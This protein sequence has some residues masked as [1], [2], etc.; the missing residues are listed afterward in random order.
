MAPYPFNPIR[1]F[2]T[3]SQKT[4]EDA[5]ADFPV[6]AYDS[7]AEA[8][9]EDEPEPRNSLQQGEYDPFNYKTYYGQQPIILGVSGENTSD[10]ESGNEQTQ[11][12][13][14]AGIDKDGYGHAGYH[15]S[16]ENAESVEF[17]LQ[18]GFRNDDIA[19]DMMAAFVTTGT[20]SSEVGLMHES[21]EPLH[22]LTIDD[23]M[24]YDITQRESQVAA[25]EGT[26]KKQSKCQGTRTGSIDPPSFPQNRT[27]A[28]KKKKKKSKPQ[29]AAGKSRAEQGSKDHLDLYSLQQ[30]EKDS[31]WSK[32]VESSGVNGPG[33]DNLP[34]EEDAMIKKKSLENNGIQ[35]PI[36]EET[37][38]FRA[39]RV[40]E[41]LEP[42]PTTT[43]DSNDTYPLSWEDSDGPY[44]YRIMFQSTEVPADETYLKL[45]NQGTKVYHVAGERKLKVNGDKS[46]KM[47]NQDGWHLKEGFLRKNAI[48]KLIEWRDSMTVAK[49][50]EEVRRRLRERVYI[51]LDMSPPNGPLGDA[52]VF[53]ESLVTLR[54]R[55]RSMP[56]W[57]PKADFFLRLEVP[58]DM[59]VKQPLE[60]SGFL[61]Y[62]DEVRN[63]L[64]E[65][66]TRFK[67]QLADSSITEATLNE[68][69]DESDDAELDRQMNEAIAGIYAPRNVRDWHGEN[70]MQTEGTGKGKTK[71][72]KKTDSTSTPKTIMHVQG[73]DAMLN[74][75]A[76]S[77]RSLKDWITDEMQE[78]LDM[79]RAE[80]KNKG[81]DLSTIRFDDNV[82]NQRLEDRIAEFDLR[83]RN[84][85]IQKCKETTATKESVNTAIELGTN[86]VKDLQYFQQ[87]GK[88]PKEHG[89][90]EATVSRM[91]APAMQSS[92]KSTPATEGLPGPGTRKWGIWIPQT[93]MNGSP[94]LKRYERKTKGALLEEMDRRDLPVDVF[95]SKLERAAAI[96]AHDDG[97]FWTAYNRA[98]AEEKKASEDKETLEDH[99][100]VASHNPGLSSSQSFGRNGFV[101]P[102][103]L[104]GMPTKEPLGV[105]DM[106]HST[107]MS[108]VESSES[109]HSAFISQDSL[110]GLRPASSFPWETQPSNQSQSLPSLAALHSGYSLAAPDGRAIQPPPPL[111]AFLPGDDEVRG[112][113]RGNYEHHNSEIGGNSN[114]RALKKHA[115][116]WNGVYSPMTNTEPLL[117]Q[118]QNLPGSSLGKRS[119]DHV[120]ISERP[121]KR[122]ALSIADAKNAA[123]CKILQPQSQQARKSGVVPTT[124]ATQ[125]RGRAKTPAMVTFPQIEEA[126]GAGM[127]ESAYHEDVLDDFS[128]FDQPLA[129]TNE[130]SFVPHATNQATGYS[131]IVRPHQ[132]EFSQGYQNKSHSMDPA[133]LWMGQQQHE[134]QDGFG[135]DM[136]SGFHDDNSNPRRP[137]AG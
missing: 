126:E 48:A 46:R 94:A 75:F 82:L 113:K 23:L 104:T 24:P 112:T 103:R 9:H 40:E 39:P 43:A 105:V 15:K 29:K 13:T 30:R 61:K 33:L 68:W 11:D 52:A 60:R 88:L 90:T 98:V 66:P 53:A 72:K 99:T 63:T 79:K 16:P 1:S 137:H 91:Q 35:G 111:Q 114:D 32:Y 10:T 25:P 118:L 14:A 106:V 81:G 76:W 42:I 41:V 89:S 57:L 54:K 22:E 83:R 108:G 120:D 77:E 45:A 73:R 96:A 127:E 67:V 74:D 123:S 3:Q 95:K 124:K 47:W 121:T 101:N 36:S 55:L 27:N 50:G 20:S 26:G 107:E 62:W 78:E 128:P 100:A 129:P 134:W 110:L 31:A 70:L 4:A 7:N 125:G 69:W 28:G 122:P 133:F 38:P 44:V 97:T 136:R 37:G 102:D 109:S 86:F 19:D 56:M 17:G 131:E 18:D 80:C 117:E 92:L 71:R 119:Y 93:K 8:S 135:L 5:I 132:Y 49:K 87:H 85:A 21:D 58:N 84:I 6:H 65:F 115:G 64:R 116:G 51:T 2:D 59:F 130:N 12:H 34:D